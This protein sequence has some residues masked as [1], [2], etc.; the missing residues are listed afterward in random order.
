LTRIA[1]L[2]KL[3][4]ERFSKAAGVGVLPLEVLTEG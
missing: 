4:Q 2:W 3:R 1:E